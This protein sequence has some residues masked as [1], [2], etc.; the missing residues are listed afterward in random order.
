VVDGSGYKA[1]LRTSVLATAAA[2]LV[3]FLIKRSQPVEGENG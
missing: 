3:S 2:L 1:A